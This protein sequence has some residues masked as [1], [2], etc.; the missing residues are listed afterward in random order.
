[1]EA[2]GPKSKEREENYN[3]TT[4]DN[5]NYK[6]NVKI[7]KNNSIYVSIVLEKDNK[8]YE[9]CKLYEE[10]KNQQTYFEDYTLEEIF[11]EIC[12]LISKNKIEFIKNEEYILFSIILPLKKKKTLDFILENPTQNI[13]NNNIFQK[14]LKQKDEIIK[15]KDD[16]I[17]KNNEIIKEKDKIIREKNNIILDLKEIISKIKGNTYDI[18][19]NENNEQTNKLEQFDYNQIFKDFNIVNLTPK[20]KLTNHGENPIYTLLQLIDGRLVSGGGYGNIIIYNKETFQPELTICEHTSG[21]YDLIQLKNGN[22][23]SC[24][25]EDKTMNL[26]QLIENNK[27][28]LLT[29]VKVQGNDCPR[30]IRELENGEIGL[31]AYESII[32]YLNINNKF[33]EDFK[34]QYDDN[35]IG[36]F[37]NMI[38]VKPG[39]LVISGEKDKIQFFEL[40]S[41]KLNEIININRNIRWDA[42]NLLCMMNERYLCVG[43]KDKIT[44]ID[45][46][47]KNII[48]E[49]EDKGTH[50]CLYKLND[51]ILLSGKE[52]DITQWKICQNNLTLMCTKEKAHQDSIRKIIKFNKFI[53]TCSSDKSIKVW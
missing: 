33:E 37:Y 29:Q 38:S 5:E 9:D 52:C 47:Q 46:Y 36:E 49:I 6:L 41:R 26:Y 27:Y 35:Q 1:M 34:I 51:N 45:V 31:V 8:I 30:K 20:N 4:S 44:I 28:K 7:K 53:V 3:K 16:I 39:E 48:R 15:E 10:I 22:L 18:N 23:I 17:K 19:I 21:I 43:G 2:P 11:D 25:P 12:E 14:I 40:N 13:D 42:D 50:Y 24:S 32:F